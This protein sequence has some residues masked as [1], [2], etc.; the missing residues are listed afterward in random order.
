MNIK[1]FE[2]IAKTCSKRP[3]ALLPLE[4]QDLFITKLTNTLNS[5]QKKLE[6]KN[7]TSTHV[8]QLTSIMLESIKNGAMDEV[9]FAGALSTLDSLY[10][11]KTQP[12]LLK[13]VHDL[14]RFTQQFKRRAQ[15]FSILENRIET[16]SANLSQENIQKHDLE[17]LK[18]I[19]LFFVL[20]YTLTVQQELSKL[21]STEQMELLSSGKNLPVGNLPGLF[22]LLESL[23]Q[24]LAFSL[25][26]KDLR[27][28]ALRSFCD[29][30]E[31]LV[32]NTADLPKIINAFK[33]LNVELLR[34]VLK[35][36]IQTFTGIFYKPYPDKTP[37]ESIINDLS[38]EL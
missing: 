26:A 22:P 14:D 33:L 9:R 31:V 18:S 20:E 19:A 11:P 10:G 16:A 8:H 2:E 25:Y 21:D 27:M 34:V 36:G 28:A 38:K 35:G 12:D 32:L 30:E 4:T 13:Q 15:E 7:L 6:K 3:F 5:L 23:R 17:S 24:E 29:F 37:I 1:L